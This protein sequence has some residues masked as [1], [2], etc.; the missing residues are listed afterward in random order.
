M[1]FSREEHGSGSRRFGAATAEEF[2]RRY[3]ACA[4]GERHAYELVREMEACHLY[5][6]LEF[7]V[8]ANA[9][10]DGVACVDALLDVLS[11][12]LP[13]RLGVSL[14]SC[15][16]VELD[17]STAA[18]FSRHLVLRLP[19]GLAFRSAAA[20]GAFVRAVWEEDVAAKR[21][22]DARADALFVRKCA[23]DASRDC[24]FVDLCV[25][26]RNR[27]FRLYLS[28]KAGKEARLLPTRRSWERLHDCGL[29]PPPPKGDSGL[30][31]P[32]EWLFTAALVCEVAH[33]AR[34][35]D[36]AGGAPSLSRGPPRRAA[37]LE[38][39]PGAHCPF[40]HSAAAVCAYA[41]ACAGTACAR[42][43]SWAV[44]SPTLLALNLSG[45][46]CEHVGRPHRSN[47]VY[48]LVDYRAGAAFQKCHD[49]D[50]RGFR[51]AACPL[52]AAAYEERA[53]LASL[54]QPAAPAAEEDAFA[55]ED[56]WLE[57]LSEAELAALCDCKVVG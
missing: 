53:M 22:S 24:A 51:G 30:A 9:G 10:V 55:A 19:G 57:A 44:L 17:S 54:Q 39:R 29:A 16:A 35:L 47:G 1:F 36:D 38:S 52:P 11:S 49:P 21:S 8:A 32:A 33:D 50:C 12:S 37:A 26:S 40:R 4:A 43:R 7:S 34:L 25:Y 15:T 14:E 13:R 6:D 20:A 28:S 23:E 5:F 46:W 27:A 2:W 42:V 18:K 45:R 31:E 56:V 48:Y 41:D 3:A